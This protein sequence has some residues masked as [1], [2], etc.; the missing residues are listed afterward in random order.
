MLVSVAGYPYF[1]HFGLLSLIVTVLEFSALPLFSASAVR[2]SFNNHH[3]KCD[4]Q[5]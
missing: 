1:S 5:K 4:M 3:F 2:I